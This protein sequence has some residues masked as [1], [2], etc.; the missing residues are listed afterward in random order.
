MFIT[1]YCCCIMLLTLLI[2]CITGM[3][4]ISLYSIVNSH[5]LPSLTI[6]FNFFQPCFTCRVVVTLTYYCL[7]LNSDGNIYLNVF[8][9][10]VVEFLG[11]L[12][13]LPLLH[14]LG[15]KWLLCA[16]VLFCGIASCC[17]VFTVLYLPCGVCRE[18]ILELYCVKFKEFIDSFKFHFKRRFL[19]L[20]L[21]NVVVHVFLQM[22][23]GKMGASAAFAVICVFSSEL[24]PTM[25]RN[26]GMG[27]S[28]MI[29]R[30][31]GMIALFIA[32]LVRHSAPGIRFH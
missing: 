31:G 19:F 9:S 30:V 12:L 18:S 29:T 3:I 27:A 20:Y 2:Q 32:D 23:V 16:S 13:C 8:L 6:K 25:I 14:R 5:N 28:C 11:Y 21:F 1:A 24:F 26:G 17:S 15:R 10:I 4:A 22:M 7:S